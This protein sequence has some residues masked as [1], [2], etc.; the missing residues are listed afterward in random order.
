MK[1]I[2]TVGIPASGKTTRYKDFKGVIVNRDD[3]RDE[4]FGWPY[5]FTKKREQD[6]Q[7][8]HWEIIEKS[9]EEGLDIAITDTNLQEGR[10]NALLKNLEDLGYEVEL[11]IINCDYELAVKQDLIRHRSVG[12]DVIWRMFKNYSKQFGIK[13]E[14]ID[15]TLD[16]C[17]VFDIDGTLAIM[18]DRGPFDWQKVGND[19]LNTN[20]WLILKM[21]IRNGF[22]VF[23]FTGR[24]ASCHEE[25]KKW[26]QDNSMGDIEFHMRPEGSQDKDF[27]IKHEMYKKHIKDKYCVL[28]VFDDRPQ[29]CRMW[30]LLGLPL[31]K[32]GDQSEF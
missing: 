6:V 10:R 14:P 19:E 25:T 24:D 4:L 27:I 26:L 11:D 32:V 16:K 18:K 28:G 8:R 22:K 31:F 13:P 23:I 20:V 2:V 3:I 7:K 12:S 1:A 15:P 9:A 21:I 30:N 5:K 17:Y 29:V